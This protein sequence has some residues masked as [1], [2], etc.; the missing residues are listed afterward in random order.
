MLNAQSVPVSKV[1]DG[2]AK[3]LTTRRAV[4]G[5]LLRNVI[6]DTVASFFPSDALPKAKLAKEQE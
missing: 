2:C 4:G 6:M 5:Y 3:A 1:K